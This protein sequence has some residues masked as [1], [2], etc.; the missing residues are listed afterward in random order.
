MQKSHVYQSIIFC[1]SLFCVVGCSKGAE[2]SLQEANVETDYGTVKKRHET[3]DPKRKYFAYNYEDIV[4]VNPDKQYGIG[5]G[6]LLPERL[7][8]TPAWNAIQ[9]QVEDEYQR[10]LSEEPNFQGA[11]ILSRKYSE[12]EVTLDVDTAFFFDNTVSISFFRTYRF[13]SDYD[14]QV[15]ETIY[16]VYS[17]KTGEELHLRDFFYK[18]TDYI[19]LLND[20]ISNHYFPYTEEKTPIPKITPDQEFY[21]DSEGNLCLDID[22]YNV[23]DPIMMS[24]NDFV[25]SSAVSEFVRKKKLNYLLSPTDDNVLGIHKVNPSFHDIEGM[26]ED[27]KIMYPEGVPDTVLEFVQK[28]YLNSFSFFDDGL[29]KEFCRENPDK[30]IC[31]YTSARINRLGPFYVVYRGQNFDNEELDLDYEKILQINETHV[32]DNKDHMPI[33]FDSDGNQISWTQIFSDPEPV[34][35]MIEDK[36]EKINVTDAEITEN[37]SSLSVE[38][39]TYGMNVCYSPEFKEYVSIPWSKLYKYL[40][41][42]YFR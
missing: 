13:G 16:K 23:G 35:S 10:L 9:E 31:V 5:S 22:D 30:E 27:V 32:W 6:V 4:N 14:H 3:K 15:Y 37:I 26:S 1:L 17:L 28:E 20:Y 7:I 25:E 8:I 18:D 41:D 40:D 39:D 29:L 21:I 38:I 12:P 19:T 36:L 2:E 42:S 11:D 33:L 24:Y 34:Y